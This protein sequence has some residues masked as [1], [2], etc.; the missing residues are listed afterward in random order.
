MKSL[1]L[2]LLALTFFVN[3]QDNQIVVEVPDKKPEEL[4]IEEFLKYLYESRLYEILFQ[5][6]KEIGNEGSFFF[7][8][9]LLFNKHCE[10]VV[11]IYMPTKLRLR[12]LASI[13]FEKLNE[14]LFREENLLILKQNN[15]DEKTL[16]EIILRVEKRFQKN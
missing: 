7:C 2:I 1:L 10:E 13:I 5:L 12:N 4:P 16:K 6:K 11:R 8:E 3:G 9:E 15:V 14:I